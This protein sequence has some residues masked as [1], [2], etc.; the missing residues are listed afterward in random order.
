MNPF[1]GC[2]NGVGPL[3][4]PGTGGWRDRTG[5]GSPRRRFDGPPL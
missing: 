1:A 3:P 5:A 4:E 2:F